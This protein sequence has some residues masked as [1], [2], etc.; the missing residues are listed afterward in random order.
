MIISFK[1]CYL[2]TAFETVDIINIHVLVRINI[3]GIN[4]NGAAIVQLQ[5]RN[6]ISGYN[7]RSH[8]MEIL[9]I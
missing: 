4:C 5:L 6:T 9:L 3:N 1:V 2:S 8:F 7:V